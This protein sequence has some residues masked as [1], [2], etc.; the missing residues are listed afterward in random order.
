VLLDLLGSLS[1]LSTSIPHT[2]DLMGPAAIP[3]WSQYV[4]FMEW[5]LDSLAEIFKNGGLAIIA[6][7]IIVKT[8]MLPLTVKS[9]RSSKAMQELAPRIKEIQKKYGQDRQKASQET[10]AL[11]NQHGVNPMAGCLPMIIQIPIFFGVYRAIVN[12][13]GSDSGHWLD[14]FV[15]LQSLEGAD[16]YK[17]LPIMA[18]VFQFVQSRM[19][20]PANQKITDPQQQIMNTMM[21]FM[22][23]MVVMFGWNFASG[24]VLYWATQSVYSVVQ[25]W[26]ITGWGSLGEWFPWLPELPEHRRLG[27]HP[28]RSIDDVMV[29]SGEPVEQK[30]FSGWLNRKMRDAQKNAEARQEALQEQ[31]AAKSGTRTTKGGAKPQAA[32]ATTGGDGDG[33]IE[34]ES[35]PA[36]KGS[37]Y[38]QRVDAAARNRARTSSNGSTPPGTDPNPNSKASRKAKRRRPAS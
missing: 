29:V 30:G 8:L 17:I 37:S 6:F 14:G 32:A 16:P 31:R 5:V 33:A 21:N 26:F 18:G 15:W 38:Q 1:L 11:Y 12:L 24:A 19:M 9:I 4:D 28:P 34:V 3:L 7:T 2:L 36:R 13:V 27:Y 20:R 25:Q 23:L 10:F 35:R 22:P